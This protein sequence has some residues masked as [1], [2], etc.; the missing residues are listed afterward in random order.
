MHHRLRLARSSPILLPIA[1][2]LA[3]SPAGAQFGPE[4]VIDASQGGVVWVHP[5]DL[6]G[7]GD[8]DVIVCR[9][10]APTLVWYENLGGG[11]FGPYQP[12]PAQP[13][14]A[15]QALTLD[16]EGDGD[17]DIVAVLDF[18][19]PSLGTWIQ[20]YRFVN[21]GGGVFPSGQSWFSPGGSNFFIALG[22]LE[23]DGDLDIF[24]FYS[25]SGLVRVMPNLGGGAFGLGQTLTNQASGARDLAAADLDGDGDAEVIVALYSKNEV[26]W[27][28]NPGAAPFGPKQVLNS[29][30]DGALGVDA[31]DLDGDGLLEPLSSSTFGFDAEVHF[32]P[33]LGGGSFG[34]TQVITTEGYPGGDVLGVDLDGDGDRD[35]LA[36]EFYGASW[37]ANDG[38]AAFGPRQVIQDQAV[39]TK[40]VEV[41]DMNGDGA[42]DVLIG[43]NSLVS[44]F[45]NQ[46]RGPLGTSYCGPAVPNSTGQP[47][48]IGAAGSL[49]VGVNDVQLTALELPPDKVGIF[50]ASRVQ[51]LTP[52]VGGGMGTLCLAQPIRRLQP[53]Q[54]SGPSGTF[55]LQLDLATSLGVPV[56]PGDTWHFQAWHRDAGGTSNLTDGLR[57]DFAP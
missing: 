3:A 36:T 17:L 35:L 49:Y 7:D 30:A 44:W 50:I 43:G 22:D 20:V 34:P 14:R 38:S 4:H 41:A 42:P 54:S 46:V 55:A 15:L 19:T 33:N 13:H 52:N 2:A 5:A 26:A 10:Q 40:R 29:Q 25:S 28:E 27:F 47:G 51:G 37:Y 53:I 21:Q 11:A 1:L 9:S 45:E 56:L 24:A 31:A 12:L 57:I 48:E 32:Y 39:A 23:G 8:P 6:D 18:Y 16:L